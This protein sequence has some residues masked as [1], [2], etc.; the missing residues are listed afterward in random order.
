MIETTQG[1]AGVDRIRGCG[2]ALVTPFGRDGRL[3]EGALREHVDRQ[4]EGG[5]D[6]LVPCGTTGETPALEPDEQVR[7]VEITAN[8]A[9]GRLPVVAGAGGNNT[10]F[11]IARGLSFK[12]VGIDAILS[13]TPYYNKPSQHALVDHFH[14][15]LDTV[16]LPM[17]LYNVPGRTSCNLLPETVQRLARHELVIGVKEAS[18]SIVQIAEI[19]AAMPDGFRLLSG[20]DGVVLPVIAVG[21]CGVISVVSNVAPREMSEFTRLCLDGDFVAARERLPRLLALTRACFLDT[22]PVP[23]KAALAMMGHMQEVYRLPMAPMAD[24]PRARLDQMLR[25]LELLHD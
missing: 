18:G 12:D 20:D 5:V 1:A 21:G 14:A 17:V 2:T 15:I 23:A 10:A 4:I 11:A 6:F 7:V 13:V 3:D 8:R 25:E 19:A 9:A 24:D 22:N 16:G